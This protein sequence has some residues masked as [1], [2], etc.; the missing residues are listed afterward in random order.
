LGC[1][2][3]KFVLGLED[4]VHFLETGGGDGGRTRRLE[5][6]LQQISCNSPNCDLPLDVVGSVYEL[7]NCMRSVVSLPGAEFVY[8]SISARPF[9]IPRSEFL[10]QVVQSHRLE[11]ES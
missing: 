7:N 11:E 8:A 1:V 6:V 3:R 5:L 10:H 2:Y 9:R 4:D